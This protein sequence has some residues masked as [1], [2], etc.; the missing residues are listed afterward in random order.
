MNEGISCIGAGLK[1]RIADLEDFIRRF[2]AYKA[3]ARQATSRRKQIEK[4]KTEDVKPSSRQ[5]AF[6]RFLVDPKE[7]LHRLA[8]EAKGLAKGYEKGENLF[9]KLDITI[10]AGEKLELAAA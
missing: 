7:K 2:R 1:D 9:Q 5:Y 6:I 4:L 8:V 3:K 10:E